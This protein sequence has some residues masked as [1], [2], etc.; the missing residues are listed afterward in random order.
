VSG[1]SEADD[2]PTL[3]KA[4]S[5]NTVRESTLKV[6]IDLGDEI[7]NESLRSEFP[8]KVDLEA[9]DVEV[10]ELVKQIPAQ[11]IAKEETKD[12]GNAA[13]NEPALVIN[14]VPNQFYE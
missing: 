14:I 12:N 2:N 1:I 8:P 7:A 9:D 6:Q 10:D 5:A 4:V 3:T 13:A 11:S